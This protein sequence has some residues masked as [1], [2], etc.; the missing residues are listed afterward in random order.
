[1]SALGTY[2]LSGTTVTGTAKKVTEYADFSNDPN[3]QEGY[4]LPVVIDPWDGAQIRS[5]RN[6]ER[7]VSL[8]DDG[9]V[10]IFLGKDAPETPWYEVKDAAG[11]TVRYTIDVTVAAL[12]RR[13]ARK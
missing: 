1:M 13:K 10:V 2:S 6:P 4:Y 7:W 5:G 9:N 8:K 12:M 11:T 3:E